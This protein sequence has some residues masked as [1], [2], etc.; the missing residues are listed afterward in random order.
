MMVHVSP[1]RVRAQNVQAP[2]TSGANGKR[3][4]SANPSTW[5]RGSINGKK[6]TIHVSIDRVCAIKAVHAA[7]GRPLLTP[8][9]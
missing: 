3:S 6:E 9:F 4:F 5:Q 7:G 1:S 2:E 8:L